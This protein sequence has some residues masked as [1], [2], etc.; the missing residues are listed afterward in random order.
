VIAVESARR[1]IVDPAK[2]GV[3]A[4]AQAYHPTAFLDLLIPHGIPTPAVLW[5]AGRG[6]SY[7]DG[8]WTCGTHRLRRATAILARN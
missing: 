8:Q 2:P 6:W 4:P 7:A 3:L 1:L 5:L